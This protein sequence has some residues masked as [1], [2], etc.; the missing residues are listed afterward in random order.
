MRTGSGVGGNMGSEEHLRR[1]FY[2]SCRY[3][4][5]TRTTDFQVYSQWYYYLLFAI[6]THIIWSLVFPPFEYYPIGKEC[7]AVF[8]TA[9]TKLWM[10]IRC[11][12]IRMNKVRLE[13]CIISSSELVICLLTFWIG[14][15]HIEQ[16][17]RRNYRE[18]LQ[19]KKKTIRQ[20]KELQKQTINIETKEEIKTLH[21]YIR[22]YFVGYS[23]R[24]PTMKSNIHMLIPHSARRKS[25]QYKVIALFINHR[26]WRS[27]FFFVRLFSSAYAS[28]KICW[29]S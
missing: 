13:R 2:Q 4:L 14:P 22:G 23:V 16:I 7:M 3:S 19:S 24:A 8:R 28:E 9:E 17:R 12:S 10:L 20:H 5:Y 21:V 6:G 25:K 26:L 18:T 27:N 1:P 15:S 11:A 29:N